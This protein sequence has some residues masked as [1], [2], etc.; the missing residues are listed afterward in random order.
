MS[1]TNTLTGTP[2]ASG[3]EDATAVNALRFTADENQPPNALE[4]LFHIRRLNRAARQSAN[5]G[6]SRPLTEI[7]PGV[8]RAHEQ[9]IDNT[10]KASDEETS[11]LARLIQLTHLTATAHAANQSLAQH[12]LDRLEMQVQSVKEGIAETFDQLSSGREEVQQRLIGLRC[13]MDVTTDAASKLCCDLR[14]LRMYCT[15][16][17]GSALIPKWQSTCRELNVTA[18]CAWNGTRLVASRYTVNARRGRMNGE[19][20]Y[21]VASFSEHGGYAKLRASKTCDSGNLARSLIDWN[22]ACQQF[23]EEWEGTHTYARSASYD[24]A[25]NRTPLSCPC[26]DTLVAQNLDH[27]DDLSCRTR[28]LAQEFLLQL[29][30]LASA[31]RVS[32]DEMWSIPGFTIRLSR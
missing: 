14:R 7:S 6:S 24:T 26:L 21:V 4:A 17:L 10:L 22:H 19:P 16:T 29:D 3:E 20:M 28:R 12:A 23:V 25:S 1:S 8:R 2:D 30:A 11:E 9:P 13:V 27:S 15:D 31:S 18:H 32:M 5:A